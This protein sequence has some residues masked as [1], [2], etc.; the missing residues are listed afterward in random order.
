MACKINAQSV[1]ILSADNVGGQIGPTANI[2]QKYGVTKSCVAD[3][4]GT[5][6]TRAGKNLGFFGKSF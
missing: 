1:V 3:K 4:D 2:G 6:D 5:P